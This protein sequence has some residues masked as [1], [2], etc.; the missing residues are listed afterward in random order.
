MFSVMRDKILQ[1][2]I[3]SYGLTPLAKRLGIRPQSLIQWRRVPLR[4]VVDFETVTGIP[5]ERIRPELYGAPRARPRLAKG[6][7][8]PVAA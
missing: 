7:R 3:D 5:R 4:R 6:N 8:L 2:A 1:A